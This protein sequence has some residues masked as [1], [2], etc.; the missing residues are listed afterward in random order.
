MMTPRIT[1]I[2][3]VGLR[4]ADLPKMIAFY[5]DTLGFEIFI[6]ESNHAFLKVAELDS[7]LG[8]IGHSLVLG[9]FDRQSPVDIQS[10]TL[11][12]LAFEIPREDYDEELAAFKA[13]GMVIRER[14]WPDTLDWRARSFFFYDP[15]GNVIEIIA[16]H[17]E[18]E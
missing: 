6:S 18:F 7:P 3:E 15:E 2:A 17:K 9:L 11:D 14:T 13:K 8:E 4:V 12:H 16:A 1:H 10:T 5:Q